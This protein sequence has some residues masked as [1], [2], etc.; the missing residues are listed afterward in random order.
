MVSHR[1]AGEK[2]LDWLIA[3][4]KK[5]RWSRLAIAEE[6]GV[7]RQ[8]YYSYETGHR[9]VSPEKAKK[10]AEIL[11]FDNFGIDWTKFYDDITESKSSDTA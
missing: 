8:A 11:K 5:E 10:I 6:L 3:I 1:K 2:M 7:S 9:K 4:R